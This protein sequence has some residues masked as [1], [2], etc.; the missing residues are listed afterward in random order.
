MSSPR[1]A[2][3]PL[4]DG[5]RRLPAPMIEVAGRSAE[6]TVQVAICFVSEGG[7]ELS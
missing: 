6:E 7:L 5:I 4:S 1:S 3:A 2:L